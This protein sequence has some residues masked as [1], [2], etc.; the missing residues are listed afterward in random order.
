MKFV[1]AFEIDAEIEYLEAV[2]WYE[3]ECEG[4]G[5]DLID[6]VEG[7][8]NA[9]RLNAYFELRYRDLRLLNVKGFPYQLIYRL[10][11]N[12]IAI[13]SFFHGNRDPEVWK[14]KFK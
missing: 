14:T 12:E 1:V 13:I 11:R 2:E 10:D 9:L 5:G 6:A 7:S 3:R 8:L 4:L